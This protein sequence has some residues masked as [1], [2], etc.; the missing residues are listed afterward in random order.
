M[1]MIAQYRELESAIAQKISYLEAIKNDPE[2]QRELA[3]DAAL[4]DFLNLHS[5]S[6][7]KLHAFLRADPTSD[8]YQK[9]AATK[10][11][12]ATGGQGARGQEPAKT[13]RNPITNELLTVKRLSHGTYK[14]W[15]E[16]YGEETVQSW[17]LA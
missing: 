5:M 7:H 10:A 12:K 9:P 16:Q 4:E 3:F 14:Q 2:L 1:T 8:F 6:K 11:K 13:F 17:L 15:V